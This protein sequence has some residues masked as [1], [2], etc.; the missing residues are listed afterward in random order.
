MNIYTWMA[1][2]RYRLSC[3]SCWNRTPKGF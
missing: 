3:H 2:T 1:E